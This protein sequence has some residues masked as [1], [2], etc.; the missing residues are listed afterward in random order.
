MDP[1]E[2]QRDPLQSSPHGVPP[3]PPSSRVSP[4]SRVLEDLIQFPL[5]PRTLVVSAGRWSCAEG[6][7]PYSILF[8]PTTKS[9]TPS[10]VIPGLQAS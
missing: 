5:F 4:E 1:R 8:I 10:L 9:C 3:A 2:T 7:S 6:E